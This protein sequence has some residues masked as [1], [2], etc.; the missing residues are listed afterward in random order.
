MHR[1]RVHHIVTMIGLLPLLFVAVALLIAEPQFFNPWN[2]L[3]PFGSVWQICLP[4]LFA[5]IVCMVNAVLGL[6]GTLHSG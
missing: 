2:N 3:Y 4:A 1:Q 6:R 5:G